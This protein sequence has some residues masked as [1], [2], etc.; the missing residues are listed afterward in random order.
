MVR[1]Y[2]TGA[3][4]VVN[5]VMADLAILGSASPNP[6]VIAVWQTLMAPRQRSQRRRQTASAQT[7]ATVSIAQESQ[8]RL[9]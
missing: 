7:A 1:C 4:G 2:S 6:L 3:V 8:D 5:A 9:T